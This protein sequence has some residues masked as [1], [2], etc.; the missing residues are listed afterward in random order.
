MLL[1]MITMGVVGTILGLFVLLAL[2]YDLFFGGK[3]RAQH[4]DQPLMG[5]M[6]PRG[7]IRLLDWQ[8]WNLID[9]SYGD[10]LI[11]FLVIA[12]LVF[13]LVFIILGSVWTFGESGLA[14]KLQAPNLWWHAQSYLIA[15]WVCAAVVWIALA[16]I[17]SLTV[18]P[19][20][21]AMGNPSYSMQ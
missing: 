4:E 13:I 12:L 7:R 14:C 16:I 20:A 2:A 17:P 11:V 21:S 9:W 19:A 8:S 15:I 5:Q 3:A 18:S 1:F 6:G 10:S